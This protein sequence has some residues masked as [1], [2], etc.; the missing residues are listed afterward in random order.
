MT[1]HV[2]A[3]LRPLAE[4]HDDVAGALRVLVEA[5]RHEPGNRRYDLFTPADG[6]PGFHLIEVYVD[7]AALDAHRAS[8]HYRNFRTTIVDWLAA[9]PEV[10]VLSGIDV[11]GG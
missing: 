4:H 2:I 6:S 3:S 8:E 10:H 9:P 11:P 7:T 1:L 5:S